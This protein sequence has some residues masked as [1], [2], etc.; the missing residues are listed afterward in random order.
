M[1]TKYP[2]YTLW[3]MM[4]RVF[5]LAL[6][7]GMIG[8]KPMRKSEAVAVDQDCH[9]AWSGIKC[10]YILYRYPDGSLVTE[11]IDGTWTLDQVRGDKPQTESK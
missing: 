6:L 10:T 4:K 5:V 1:P 3:R 9:E 8:C 2:D 11:S 7:C